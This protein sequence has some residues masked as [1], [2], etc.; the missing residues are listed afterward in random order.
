MSAF[1]TYLSQKII[2]ST[3]RGEAFAL[4]ATL[5]LA[6]FSSSPTDDNVTSGEI[7]GDWY[8]RQLATSW[9]APVGA[10]NATANSNQIQY[11]AVTG[12]AV[13]ASHWGL[14]DAPTGG[15]LLYHGAHTAPKTL[16]VG[17]VIVVG[18][19]QLQITVD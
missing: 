6:Q 13:V 15:N 19:G 8:S 16:N 2:N 12:S 11:P 9:S 18:I 10:G 4:P 5:Y 7:S 1:S 14:Y 3:L 17:D